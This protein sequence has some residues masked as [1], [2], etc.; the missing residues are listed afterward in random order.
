MSE[1][2]RYVPDENFYPELLEKFLE[3]NDLDEAIKQKIRFRLAQHEIGETPL[4]DRMEQIPYMVESRFIEISEGV[5]GH[6]SSVDLVQDNQVLW[7]VTN[8]ET[9]QRNMEELLNGVSQNTIAV[10]Q[11]IDDMI[12][13]EVFIGSGFIGTDVVRNQFDT[14]PVG[15]R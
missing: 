7:G 11:R 1:A 4:V 5:D 14:G 15:G 13:M 8:R 6:N 10:R 12:S 9:L 3:R 2:Q